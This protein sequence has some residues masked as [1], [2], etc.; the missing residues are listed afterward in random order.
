MEPQYNPKTTEEKIYKLWEKSGF[1]NPDNLKNAKKPFTITIPPPNVTGSLHMGH[2]LNVVIQD[3]LIRFKRMAGF[4]TL[5]VPGTDH[6]GIATQ[7]MVEKKLKK[8]GKTRFDLGREKFLEEIWKWKNEYG[9]KILDQLKRLGASCDWSRAR[10]TMDK[11]YSAAVLEAFVQYYNQGWIYRGERAVNWCPRCQT[12]L[13]DLE[14]EHKE[15]KTHLW[16]LKYPLADRQNEFITVATTRPE[17]MLGDTAVAVN[18]KN[19]RYK[20]LVGQMVM[21]PL[22]NREIPIIADRAID[23]NFGTG[24]VKVTPAHSLVDWQIGQ[25]HNLP[26][27]SVIDERC[28]LNANAPEIYRDMKIE[29]ARKKIVEDLSTLNLIEKIKDY[30][31]SVPKCYRCGSTVELIPSKQWF[32]KMEKL[33]KFAILPI[34]SGK[35]K[36]HPK[37]WEKVY[38]DWL[39]NAHDWCV[40]R[41]IWWGHQFPVFFCQKK[42]ENLKSKISNLKN[43]KENF[44]ISI[45]KP[46]ECPFCHECAMRQ[47]E[48]VFDTWFSS[49]LW[50]FAVLGWPKKTKDLSTYYPTDVLSTACDII[51]LWVARMVYS[52]AALAKKLPFKDVIIHATVTTKEGK[53][54]SKSLDTGIDPLEVVEKYGADATRFGLAWQISET[55]D[56]RFGEDDILAGKK[57]CNKIWNASRFV[58]QNANS[59][60]KAQSVKPQFKIKNL[61][62]ADKKILLGIKKLRK[63]TKVSIEK[64][65]F[66]K[67]LH[68]LYEFFWHQ[69]AD[70][71]IETAKKQL[72]DEKI[73][74]QTQKILLKVHSGLLK[75][76]HP[77]LPFITEEIWQIFG[78]STKSKKLIMVENW[79]K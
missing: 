55:Q 44:I 60:R 31:H 57:F 76:L 19:E 25:N 4:K 71:Y 51:N 61:T 59:K 14:L 2:A 69:Y 30:T 53:R 39:K 79:P 5:W 18:P 27:I 52:G 32:V 46:K 62:T 35:I 58:I 28:R 24:A 67:A 23:I 11:D 6:A 47:S 34:K 49:A 64:Y 65:E 17:T 66:G 77:F 45:Q 43:N 3:I 73:R 68:R 22:A 50:P 1:F 15:E 78:E 37:R 36:F 16:Y 42:Q 54:M 12:S 20:K 29:E 40:S 75:L 26:I 7:S 21:L 10:F 9:N 48:D 8:E 63:D 72:A 74:E 56:M 38:L 41:Q 70:I 13:S 33:A